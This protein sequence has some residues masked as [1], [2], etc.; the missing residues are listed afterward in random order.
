M[1]EDEGPN[2]KRRTA[3]AGLT[4]DEEKNSPCGLDY[5]R[6]LIHGKE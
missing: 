6:K 4:T 1:T 5:E 3:L 2:T